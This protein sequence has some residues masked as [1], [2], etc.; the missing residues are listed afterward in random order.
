MPAVLP[1]G[2]RDF[3]DHVVPI[4]RAGG[5]FRHEYTGRTL[6]EHYGLERPPNQHLAAPSLVPNALGSLSQE[7]ERS[8]V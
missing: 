1:S 2:L 7:L 5:L 6:R 8:A 4:L 3:V